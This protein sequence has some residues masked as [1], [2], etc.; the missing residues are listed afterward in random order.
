MLYET[1]PH[2]P[3]SYVG[4]D[5]PTAIGS[6]AASAS[7]YTAVAKENGR[8]DAPYSPPVVQRMPFEFRSADGSGNNPLAPDLGKAGTPYARTVQAK[9]PTVRNTLPDTGLVFDTLLKARDVGFVIF[10][11]YASSF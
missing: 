6:T 4:T 2:P 1:L 7:N 5:V 3:A 11:T 9:H 8:S 10:P